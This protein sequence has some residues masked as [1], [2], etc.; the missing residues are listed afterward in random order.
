MTYQPRYEQFARVR[1]FKA[2]SEEAP[3]MH[4]FISWIRGKWL[5]WAGLTG[6]KNLYGLTPE[7]HKNFD[8]WLL[9]ESE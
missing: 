1:G 2:G 9:E 7:D 8:A 5:I 6:R 4:E 3:L